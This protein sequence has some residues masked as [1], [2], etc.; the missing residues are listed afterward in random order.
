MIENNEV[1]TVTD[2]KYSPIASVVLWERMD[3]LIR[4]VNALVD[5]HNRSHKSKGRKTCRCQ[6]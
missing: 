1:T 2:G 3:A 6:R 4:T 5:A